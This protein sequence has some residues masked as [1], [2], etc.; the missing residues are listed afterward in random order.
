MGNC[1]VNPDAQLAWATEWESRYAS[2]WVATGKRENN[3]A[4]LYAPREPLR[5]VLVETTALSPRMLPESN[6]SVKTIRALEE[7][8]RSHVAV[9]GIEQ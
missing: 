7:Q 4:R 3:G 2:G 6:D 9:K 1:A 8:L 5:L